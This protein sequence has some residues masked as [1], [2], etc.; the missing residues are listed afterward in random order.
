VLYFVG[1]VV[2]VLGARSYKTIPFPL[3]YLAPVVVTLSFGL[4][5]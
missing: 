2:T 1:A 5:A 3:L 4:T